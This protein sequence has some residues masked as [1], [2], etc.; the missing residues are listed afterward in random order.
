MRS[1]KRRFGETMPG[2]ILKGIGGAAIA[3]A[4]MVAILALQDL[5]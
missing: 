4:W 2:M 5:I 1:R 3:Y